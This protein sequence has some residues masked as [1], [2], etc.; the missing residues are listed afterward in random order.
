M[1]RKLRI[2]LVSSGSGSRGGGEIYLRFLAEGLAGAGHEVTALVPDGAQMDELATQ[3]ADRASVTRYPHK[4][5]YDRRFRSL[6]A[7]VDVGHQRRLKTILADCGVDVLHINQQ[8]AEDALD[9][10][11]AAAA[12]GLPWVST[13]HVGHGAR[14]LGAHL[15]AVRDRITRAILD[16]HAG[17]IISV[18]AASRRQ[19]ER[20]FTARVHTVLNGVPSPTTEALAK[21]RQAARRDWGAGPDS[22]CVGTVGRIAAQKNPDAFLRHLGAVAGR[23][24][25][26][27]AVWIGDGAERDALVSQQRVTFPMLALKIDGWRQDAAT[28]MAGLDVYVLSSVFEGLPLALLEAMHAGL[29][30]I[31]NDI[32]G[33]S[34]VITDGETGFVC[35]SD[36]DWHNALTTVLGNP[37]LRRD[38]GRAARTAAATRLSADAMAAQTLAVY[39]DVIDRKAARQ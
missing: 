5:T 2:G 12:T 31:A 29:P 7:A 19:L 28:R 20:R 35:R 33:V 34:E 11:I 26:L 4:P 8:V 15:G 23:F 36:D 27:T 30:I 17:A 13:I 10:V 25:G 32:D 22:I 37:T 3:L 14:A 24:P 38:M 6:G 39:Q 21:A 16:R 18:S 9:L 1:T